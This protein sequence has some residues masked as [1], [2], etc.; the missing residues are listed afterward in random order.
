MGAEMMLNIE[1]L[2]NN[3]K[4]TMN[5][6]DVTEWEVTLLGPENSPYRHGLFKLKV[7]FPFDYPFKP[8]KA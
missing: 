2:P 8:L 3:F 5:P 4:F 7:N 1:N 6:T